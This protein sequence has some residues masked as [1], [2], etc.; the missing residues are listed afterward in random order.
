MEF[1]YISQENKFYNV[2]NFIFNNFSINY[3]MFES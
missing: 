2:Y 1:K 3:N